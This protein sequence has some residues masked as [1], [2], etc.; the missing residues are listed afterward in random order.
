MKINTNFAQYN[1]NK[2]FNTNFSPVNNYHLFNNQE[3][4]LPTKFSNFK[5]FKK[6]DE[7]K[8]SNTNT[9]QNNN[10]NDKEEELNNNKQEK[11]IVFKT[12]QEIPMDYFIEKEKE[13]NF[14][15]TILGR[16]IYKYKNK[17]DEWTQSEDDKLN[18]LVNYYGKKNFKKIAS[19][20]SDKSRKNCINR[21]TKFISKNEKYGKNSL[22]NNY[23]TLKKKPWHKKEDEIILKWV[24][25]IGVNNWTK[26]SKL[27][28][29]RTPKDCKNRW[30]NKLYF[31]NLN[32]TIESDIWTKKD[33]FLIALYIKKFGNC[34]SK[35][36][37]FFEN[38]TANQIKNKFNCLLRLFYKFNYN[39][40]IGKTNTNNDL[41][42]FSSHSQQ[43]QF[44]EKNNNN[45]KEIFNNFFSFLIH[46]E[47]E[48]VKKQN[49]LIFMEAKK[50]FF[51]K[52]TNF[53]NK[54]NINL[55]NNHHNHDNCLKNLDLSNINNS[56]E[57]KELNI[58]NKCMLLL[59]NHIKNRIINKLKNANIQI[60]SNFFNSLS[61]K[62]KEG[63]NL[64]NSN[65]INIIE[66][67]PDLI[68]VINNIKE[69]IIK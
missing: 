1:I 2:N 35:L 16:R 63:N 38:K 43:F 69:R 62:N 28:Y 56:N 57:I 66:K 52:M 9:I 22:S 19:H 5:N 36:Q 13:T 14:P 65:E 15:K 51:I 47:D 34:W 24:K 20:F 31:E 7:D 25:K 67:I 46:N 58:C 40:T 29:E 3:N 4:S 33:E 49:L 32:L 61:E 39:N 27:F 12:T 44:N 42:L 11:K 18:D 45:N 54:E 41:F 64:Y 26:C 68:D 55:N 59:R 30:F 6:F 53:F 17:K 23:N 50:D 37:N 60:N 10:N 48:Y 8:T 21:W